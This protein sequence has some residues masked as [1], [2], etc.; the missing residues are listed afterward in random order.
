MNN[1]PPGISCAPRP[2]I[3]LACVPQ[4]I[5]L[6]FFEPPASGQIRG[7]WIRFHVLRKEDC[8]GT[9]ADWDKWGEI[10]PYFGV[11]SSDEYRSGNLNEEGEAKFFRSGEQYIDQVLNE[12]RSHLDK[13]FHPERSLDFGCGVGR[14]VIPLAGASEQVVGVDVSDHMLAEASLNCQKRNVENVSFIKSDDGLTKLTGTFNLIHSCL[15][16]QHIPEKRGMPLI[17]AML[18]HLDPGGVVAIQFYYRCDAPKAIRA[19]VKLRYA[20]PIANYARNLIRGRPLREPAMQ[21]HDYDLETVISLL[22]EAGVR[23]I[24]LRPYSDY[25]FQGVALYGQKSDTT[26][27]E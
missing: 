15:V 8:L 19:L 26:A 5:P 16:L 2:A 27:P 20:M 25:G 4:V 21:L 7:D 12:L 11:L 10:D 9:D 3:S 24:Y 17:E 22:N 13:D 6:P 14:L 23:S 1:L 18:R